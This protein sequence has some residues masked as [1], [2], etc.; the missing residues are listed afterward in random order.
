MLGVVLNAINVC[1]TRLKINKE[2]ILVGKGKYDFL[3]Q[4]DVL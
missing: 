1:P 3:W 4:I 2:N